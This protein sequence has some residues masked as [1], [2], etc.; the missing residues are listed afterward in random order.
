VTS[1]AIKTI[2]RNTV[3][4]VST[5]VVNVTS[6]LV[7]VVVAARILG[8]DLYA[9]L[10]YSM[11][12]QLSFLPLALF[13]VGPALSYLIGPDRSRIRDYAGH[14]L[15]IRLVTIIIAVT[16]CI[17]FS[18]II[19]PDP[20]APILIAILS[21]SLAARALTTYTHTLFTAFEINQYTMRQETFFGFLDLTV[22]LGILLS[23]G[24]LL[25]LVS[26]KA[27]IAW[28]QTGWALRAAHRLVMPIHLEWQPAQWRPLLRLALPALMI[29]LAVDWSFNGSLILFRN[30]TDDGIL[31]GQYALAMRILTI[32]T[33]LPL[34]LSRA[35]F[36][37][38]RRA[39]A[40]GD[41]K[42]LLFASTMQRLAPVAGT[43]AG[44]LGWVLGEPFFRW[45][46]GNPFST[47]GEL[48][49]LTLWCLIPLTA[50]AGYPEVLIAQ[51]RFRAIVIV[52]VT[53]AVVMTLLTFLL[54]PWY[55][56]TGAIVAA[57]L[58]FSVT[59]GGAFWLAW[60]QKQADP[61]NEVVRPFAAASLGLG[62]FLA[63]ALF[64]QWL[65]LLAGLLTLTVA[66]LAFR[67]IDPKE[68]RAIRTSLSSN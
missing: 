57:F 28:L 4:L 12:W 17:I 47:A 65:A 33:I 39:V 23:G 50:G 8:P 53:G 55:G 59:P 30:L 29:T 61:I 15:A 32:A 68:I 13:G 21:L 63:L 24:D 51:G 64:S 5:R 9:L 2:T 42:E 6:R 34:A 18:R 48:V 45:M 14:V 56:V 1:P 62:I 37:A 36:P 35:I 66:T 41:G 7:W 11:T 25:L 43:A 20:R 54:V 67:V 44:L 26:A 52:S 49:G 46:L 40:R 22:A 3:Y 10:A 16:M 19:M 60:R 58:G 38:L 27:V 31:F